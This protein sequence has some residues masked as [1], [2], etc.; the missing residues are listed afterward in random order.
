MSYM[1]GQFQGSQKQLNGKTVFNHVEN[2]LKAVFDVP[3]RC[4]P[5]GRTDAG[6]HAKQMVFHADV[7]FQ[8]NTAV[9]L[10][11]L[12]RHLQ[13][14]DIIISS[15]D[16]VP[17]SFHA[18]SSAVSRRYDYLFA[19]EPVPYYLC[20]AVAVI[21]G[22]PKF[23]PSKK[24]LEQIF[25]GDKNM[26]FLSNTAPSKSTIR[27]VY[28]V[29]IMS[30]QHYDLFGNPILM[31]RFQIEANGFLYRMVR[32]IVGLLLHSMV[33]FTNMDYLKDYIS[34]HRSVRYQLAP[35]KGLHLNDVYYKE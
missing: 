32:H 4:I 5:A 6:V 15:I 21:E 14:V 10:R 35:A 9:I 18:L 33:N 12:N 13:A 26:R 16:L 34:I 22:S 7:E 20:S 3:I 17:L 25:L 31:Y 27:H 11:T 29:D 30:F 8:F 23:I 2:A 19:F 1:G 24:V 28:S